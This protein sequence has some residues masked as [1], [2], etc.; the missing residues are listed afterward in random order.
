M[1]GGRNGKDMELRNSYLSAIEQ[2]EVNREDYYAINLDELIRM[3]S[4]HPARCKQHL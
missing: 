3:C 1:N 2:S 4:R